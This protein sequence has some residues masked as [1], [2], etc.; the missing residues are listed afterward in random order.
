[1][2]ALVGAD[3][4]S[5]QAMVMD[6]CWSPLDG[7]SGKAEQYQC[8]VAEQAR[9]HWWVLISHADKPWSWM[10]AARQWLETAVGQNIGGRLLISNRGIGVISALL[11]NSN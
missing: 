3:Q 11:L 9:R 1:M 6:G 4:P 5:R 10:V 8:V 2:K 7:D